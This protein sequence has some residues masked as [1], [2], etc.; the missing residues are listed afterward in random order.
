MPSIYELLVQEGFV[1][2]PEDENIIQADRAFFAARVIEWI[3]T[4]A[5]EPDF[6]LQAY[7]VALTYYKLGLAE[8]KFIDKELMYR[9]RGVDLGGI[10]GE[11]YEDPNT[12]VGAFHRPD[13]ASAAPPTGA[14][15]ETET[16]DRPEGPIDD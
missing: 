8:M 13:E 9:Y 6:N 10:E 4:R 16:T 14:P 5:A 2:F 1:L 3:R 7:L 12:V 11:V 15:E